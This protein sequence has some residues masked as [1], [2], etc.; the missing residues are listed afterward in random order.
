MLK[1]EP[2]V[3][4]FLSILKAWDGAIPTF[5]LD[6]EKGRIYLLSAPSGL[7][8]KFHEERGCCPLVDGKLIVEFFAN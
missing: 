8:K 6:Y 5:Q 3:A 7:I 4:K 1:F 2:T